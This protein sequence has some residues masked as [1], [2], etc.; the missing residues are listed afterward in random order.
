MVVPQACRQQRQ[1]L[2]NFDE[3]VMQESVKQVDSARHGYHCF[4][5]GSGRYETA[6][7]RRHG[8]EI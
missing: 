4:P 8:H 6:P 7:K 2:A 3:A 5:D 1:G